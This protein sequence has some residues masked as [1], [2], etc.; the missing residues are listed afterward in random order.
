M[1]QWRDK[2][3]DPPGDGAQRAGLLLRAG[4]TDPRE[5]GRTRPTR[6]T[7]RCSTSTGTTR[8]TSTARSTG[9]GG[10]P[11]DQRHRSGRRGAVGVPGA[12][13]R[14]LDP[15]RLLDLLRCLR[16]RGQPGT[17]SQAALGAGPGRRRVGLGVAGS[18]G[19]SSTTARRPPPTGRRGA[20]ARSTSG[21]TPRPA[22]GPA[23]TCPTS[24]PTGRRT[25]CRKRAP[26][27]PTRSAGRTRS[28]C[29]PTARRGC[30]RRSGVADGPHADALR[31]ARVADAQPALRAA[32]ATRRDAGCRTSVEP[33][34]PE[35]ERGLPLR[36]HHLPA[37]R[38]PHRGRD[39]PHPAVP[40]RA[41]A[42]AVLRGVAAAG[43]R[44]R[45]RERRLGDDH[46]RADRDRGAGAGDRPAAV[47]AARR[48]RG[49]AGRAALPLGT[50]TA[51]RHG[52]LR[53]RPGQRHAGPQRLHPGQGRHLRHPARAADRAGPALTAY[54][55]EY[56]RRAGRSEPTDGGDR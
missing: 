42:R 34:Q 37:D 12:E 50:A 44:A 49:R 11:R 26:P 7:G 15:V 35:P 56:R 53:Q 10:A 16:R 31:A 23:S 39:E 4:P 13:A 38:A 45:A 36:L 20:S 9:R 25:S 27:G 48:P 17:T 33:D 55:E 54:V 19:A 51:S 14:R 32:E 46:H 40:L 28:S 3:V 47:A 43:A 8:S 30:S 22:G 6:W 21:G 41:A 18:T 24:S 5:A 52:R 29:R 1:L 2:A